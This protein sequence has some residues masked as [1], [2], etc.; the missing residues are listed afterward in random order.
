MEITRKNAF[1]TECQQY[2]RKQGCLQVLAGAEKVAD[3]S[4]RRTKS[5]RWDIAI[6]SANKDYDIYLDV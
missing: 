5:I 4:T 1:D 6:L 3:F 2:F